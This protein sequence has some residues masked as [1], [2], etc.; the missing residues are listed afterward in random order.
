MGIRLVCIVM[1]IFYIPLRNVLP[2]N[3]N[4]SQIIREQ[5]SRRQRCG[6]CLSKMVNAGT[7]RKT[8]KAVGKN[9]ENTSLKIYNFSSIQNIGKKFELYK[10][11]HRKF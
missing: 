6:W 8:L 1:Y 7:F 2:V 11:F 4:D 5:E 9:I 3:I 10:D